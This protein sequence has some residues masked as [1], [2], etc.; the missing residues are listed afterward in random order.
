MIPTY[1]G[2]RL[3]GDSQEYANDRLLYLRRHIDQLKGLEHNLDAI[4]VIVNKDEHSGDVESYL[5]SINGIMIRDACVNF[6]TRVNIGV[7]YGAYTHFFK[8]E[9]LCNGY[10]YFIMV[11]DDYMPALDNFDAKL[12]D[13]FEEEPGTSFLCSL[14][15]WGCNGGDQ[16]H[17][18]ISNG[19]TNKPTVGLL[20]EYNKLFH[21]GN[22]NDVS[23]D[24]R[25]GQVMFSQAFMFTGI[26]RDFTDQ[27]KVPYWHVNHVRMYGK[28]S[29]EVLISPQQY[30]K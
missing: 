4:Y 5:S 23:N 24:G 15:G 19:I 18:A 30:V 8:N 26:M 12:V 16:P 28:H 29:G 10:D 27:Y 6:M 13:M 9:G 22:R 7:S 21:S 17:A 11:E 1:L 14:I 25:F 3:N 20:R 2:P